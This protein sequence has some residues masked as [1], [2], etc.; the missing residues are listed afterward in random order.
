M[1]CRPQKT[2]T[3]FV[4]E[5]PEEIPEDDIRHSLYKFRSVVEVCR[6]P[7]MSSSQTGVSSASSGEFSSS[8]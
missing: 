5:I 2:F 7:P 4:F 8:R 1:P 3:I 6:L